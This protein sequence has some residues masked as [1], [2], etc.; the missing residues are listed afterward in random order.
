M[1]KLFFYLL[2]HY[3]YAA[4][5]LHGGNHRNHD[6]YRSECTGTEYCAKLC[7]VQRRISQTV[8][9]GTVAEE[10]I[11]FLFH[12]EIWDSFVSSDIEASDDYR[13]FFHRFHGFFISL[14]LLLFTGG[15]ICVHKEK[16][17]SEKSDSLSV[18]F[19]CFFGVFRSTDVTEKFQADAVFRFALFSDEVFQSA[20]FP[21]K[22]FSL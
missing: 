19:F 20:L 11:L 1:A 12:G 5:F 4:K 14:K 9:N 8:A 15:M 21:D 10:R 7:L 13:L 18:T 3:F 16:F 22:V 17:G 2:N 6:F